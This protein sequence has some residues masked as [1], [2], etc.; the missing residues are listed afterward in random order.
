MEPETFRLKN[1]KLEPRVNASYHLRAMK[2]QWIICGDPLGLLTDWPIPSRK[3]SRFTT[4]TE[5]LP[6]KV[7]GFSAGPI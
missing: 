5:K 6:R 1:V 2:A 7:A 3:M 4:N